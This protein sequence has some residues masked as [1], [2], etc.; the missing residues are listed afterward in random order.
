MTFFPCGH[1]LLLYLTLITL[2]T[3]SS[4]IYISIK[5]KQ[6][7]V[8]D[9]NNNDFVSF[10]K[11]IWIVC[12]KPIFLWCLITLLKRKRKCVKRR[13]KITSNW[14]KFS[15]LRCPTPL[16]QH[17]ANSCV[18]W[19]WCVEQFCLSSSWTYHRW[20]PVCWLCCYVRPSWYQLWIFQFV[21]R[22]NPH[23]PWFSPCCYSHFQS[24]VLWY[25]SLISM[26]FPF[27]LQ[28][29]SLCCPL[30]YSLILPCTSSDFVETLIPPDILMNLTCFNNFFPEISIVWLH[31]FSD[32][33][34]DSYVFTL[35]GFILGRASFHQA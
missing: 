27:Q 20:L 19:C 26:P 15:Y 33:V 3:A 34:K 17:L 16:H 31:H 14:T 9:S 11:C 35:G 6:K 7:M 5:R 1:Q 18:L 8:V 30:L 25:P 2:C 32:S 4:L 29:E 13:I 10:V 22:F 23:I 24:W 28:M 21:F 12:I